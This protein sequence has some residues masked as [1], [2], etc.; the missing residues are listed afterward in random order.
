MTSVKLVIAKSQTKAPKFVLSN[1]TSKTKFNKLSFLLSLCFLRRILSQGALDAFHP[2]IYDL[3]YM[4]FEKC[5]ALQNSR[6]H[7][8]CAR[9]SCQKCTIFILMIIKILVKRLHLHVYVSVCL[10][11]V[12]RAFLT[13]YV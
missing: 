5:V 2:R 12:L 6:G 9:G 1:G 8:N 13:R 4:R 7:I 11:C 3:P 10:S